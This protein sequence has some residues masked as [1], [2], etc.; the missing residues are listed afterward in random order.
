VAAILVPVAI[1]I[2]ISGLDD[3]FI[4]L[5]GFAA[6][7]V[8]FPWPSDADVRRAAERPIAVFVPLWHEQAVIGR[9]LEHNL[10]AIRYRNYHFF[11]GV[12]PNDGPTIRAVTEQAQRHPRVH[13]ATC[14]HDG[15]TS[16]AD[17][18]NW[19][20]Q[21][22]KDHEARH[23]MRFR[24]VVMHDAED[25]IHPASLGLINWFSR[26]YAMEFT[27][28]EAD[29]G[30]SEEDLAAIFKELDALVAYLQTRG[31]SKDWRPDN[32]YEK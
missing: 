23:G 8:R 7:R 9:M 22:M 25:L 29:P 3:L 19:I 14:P 1:W 31:R 6:S 17:C 5:V 15:P 16:K 20:Y 24:I 13:I 11:V 2:A 32:D 4:T 10:A 12:Y 27:A 30:V 28:R 21:R 18:L 26:R